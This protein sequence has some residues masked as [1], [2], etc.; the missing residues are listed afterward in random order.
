MT[1]GA[2]PNAVG[3]NEEAYVLVKAV[4]SRLLSC[5]RHVQEEAGHLGRRVWSAAI[6]V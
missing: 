6:G 2:E 3:A 5:L 4:R 1:Y